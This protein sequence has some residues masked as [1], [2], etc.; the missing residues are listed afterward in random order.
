MFLQKKFLAGRDLIEKSSFGSKPNELTI[1]LT[2]YIKRQFHIFIKVVETAKFDHY[3]RSKAVFVAKKQKKQQDYRQTCAYRSCTTTKNYLYSITLVF[4][5]QE[6]LTNYFN[7]Y[8]L[9]RL[10]GLYFLPKPPKKPLP[11]PNKNANSFIL[12]IQ[13]STIIYLA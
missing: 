5:C 7:L 4:A 10:V 13:H 11:N 1:I 12:V 6:F 9:V 3:F 2:P 8:V